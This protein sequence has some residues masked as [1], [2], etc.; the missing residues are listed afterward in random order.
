M[1]GRDIQGKVH[2]GTVGG[3]AGGFEPVSREVDWAD[4]RPCPSGS[5]EMIR[6]R[7]PGSPVAALFPYESLRLSD[8]A[9]RVCLWGR[10][11]HLRGPGAGQQRG[12]Q[13]WGPFSC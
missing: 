6:S 3:Q 13:V 4:G 11:R 9:G 1:V 7:P 2:A 10:A 12:A 5:S 8:P